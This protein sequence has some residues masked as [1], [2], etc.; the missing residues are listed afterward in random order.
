[1]SIESGSLTLLDEQ[2]DSN[3]LR[4]LGWFSIGMAVAAIGIFVGREM[5]E[6]LQVQSA[7]AL[8][9]LLQCRRAPIRRVWH[10]HLSRFKIHVK[11]MPP[12]RGICCLEAIPERAALSALGLARSLILLKFHSAPTAQ[13]TS[14]MRR[15]D[16]IP[17]STARIEFAWIR[18][19]LHAGSKGD[20]WLPQRNAPM[21]LV[22][23]FRRM[24]RSSAALTAK[25]WATEWKWFASAGTATAVE[26]QRTRNRALHIIFN[27]RLALP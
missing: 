15:V 16:A 20:L 21:R 10:G 6:A 12:L 2:D 27:Q 7:H 18:S 24:A 19:G 11:S 8:R 26:M 9:F 22:P 13:N 4:V 17:L 3:T 1:M 14:S 25:G 5:R 23:A